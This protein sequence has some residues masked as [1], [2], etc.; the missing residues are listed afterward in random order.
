MRDAMA[1]AVTVM[2]GLPP[3]SVVWA[4]DLQATSV[5]VGTRAVLTA[6]SVKTLGRDEERRKDDPVNP[7]N[8]QVVSRCGQRNFTWSIKLE[9]QTQLP[10]AT[11]RVLADRVRVRLFRPSVLAILNAAGMS[12][13]D[14]LATNESDYL[15]GGRSASWANI[16]LL[17]NAVEND[18]DDT[19]G[20]GDW[21]GDAQISGTVHDGSTSV[22]VTLDVDAR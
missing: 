6:N 16:D 13:A 18:T 4:G 9:S 12:V 8:D 15:I 7:L 1:E 20:T 17:M 22:P 2:A 14:I 10:G 5:V 11:V 3:G 19:V 21:I